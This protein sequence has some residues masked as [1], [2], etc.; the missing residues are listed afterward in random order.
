MSYR[1]FVAMLSASLFLCVFGLFYVGIRSIDWS[2]MDDSVYDTHR[3]PP[4]L[5]VF[6]QRES[7]RSSSFTLYEGDVAWFED[8]LL[9]SFSGPAIIRSNG[10]REYWVYGE[11]VS[12]STWQSLSG[13]AAS[14]LMEFNGITVKFR[15]GYVEPVVPSA[16]LDS[17][18]LTYKM[19]SSSG[20]FQ[21]HKNINGDLS[22][23]DGPALIS[24]NGSELWAKDGL[25]HRGAG[26]AITFS[27]GSQWYVQYG[28]FIRL[29]GPGI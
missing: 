7:A 27:D 4:R 9:H 20:F 14:D 28:K 29:V 5:P 12:L 26:P 1:A 13:A 17:D 25:I 11:P 8:G 6:Y 24:L 15:D 22:E 2:W 18:S 21:L 23:V 3:S 19:S 16:A 10:L